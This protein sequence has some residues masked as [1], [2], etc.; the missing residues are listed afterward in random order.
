[1]IHPPRPTAITIRAKH[2]E[3][4]HIIHIRKL[5]CEHQARMI[6]RQPSTCLPV[7]MYYDFHIVFRSERRADAF[8][9]AVA[10]GG[11]LHEKFGY[12]KKALDTV[13]GAA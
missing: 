10:A 13:K 9:R 8:R 2:L 4:I 6:L 3:G 7:P 11:M 12:C 5:A 1:M